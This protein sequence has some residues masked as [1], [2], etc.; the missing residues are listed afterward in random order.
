MQRARDLIE[1]G[2]AELPVHEELHDLAA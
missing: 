2:L 1:E